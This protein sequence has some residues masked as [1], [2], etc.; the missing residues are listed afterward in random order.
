MK[1]IAALITGFVL[2]ISPAIC[3]ETDARAISDGGVVISD[4][5]TLHQTPVEGTVYRTDESGFA[6]VEISGTATPPTPTPKPDAVLSYDT[7]QEDVIVISSDKAISNAKLIMTD[8][9]EEVGDVKVYDV[10]TDGKNDTRINVA[11]SGV[12]LPRAMLWNSLDDMKPLAPALYRPTGALLSPI[13]LD[14][15]NTETLKYNHYSLHLSEDNTFGKKVKLSPGSYEL[16]FSYNMKP[17]GKYRCNF[18]VEQGSE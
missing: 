2:A 1:K 7:E 18:I 10:S 3:A 13:E 11:D 12:E 16:I 4:G 15:R 6:E 17:R 8:Y 5:C 14:I 9:S